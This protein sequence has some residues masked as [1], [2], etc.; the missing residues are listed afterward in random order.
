M[1]TPIFRIFD[2]QQALKFY[3]D[4]LGFRID[5]EELPAW[6]PLYMQVSRG[7]IV[8]HLT[9]HHGDSCPGLKAM[10][11]VKGL[12]T[13]HHLLRQ[14]DYL[15]VSHRTQ[16]SQLERQSAANRS[17]RPLWQPPRIHGSLRV[18][19]SKPLAPSRR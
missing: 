3:V 17:D 8:L 10:V 15:F 5:W 7:D 9:G 18:S 12:V 11:E 14:K 16:K 13:Y 19:S 4:W 6:S 2:Y 1:A